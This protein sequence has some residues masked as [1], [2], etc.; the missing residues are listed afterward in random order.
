MQN[1]Q[2]ALAA[3]AGFLMLIAVIL[4]FTV[5][6]NH[7]S[8]LSGDAVSFSEGWVTVD[9][10]PTSLYLSDLPRGYQFTAQRTAHSA[11]CSGK[12][13]C[14]VSMNVNLAV[15]LDDVCI[16]RFAPNLGGLYGK[17]YGRML[18]TVSLPSYTGDR[19]L[20]IEMELLRGGNLTGMYNIVLQDSGAYVRDALR[21]DT[22]KFV[23]GLLNFGFGV[24]LLMI[25]IA[26]E[27]IRGKMVEPLCL[28]ATAM[29]LSIWTNNENAILL[30]VSDNPKMIRLLSYLALMLIPIPLIVF[31]ASL[32]K[33]ME[34]F[35]VRI[36]LL[37]S[38]LNIAM[39][40]ILVST[41]IC[42]YHDILIVSH[43]LILIG[44]CEIA[45]LLISAYIRKD[46]TRYQTMFIISAICVIAAGGIGDMFRFY[47]VHPE[48]NSAASRIAMLFFVGIL[49]VYEFR[50]Q[51]S[52][53][54]RSNEAELM[55]KLAMEDALTGLQNR[56]AFTKYEQCLLKR[57]KG[58]CLFLHFDVNHLKTVNDT[59]GHAAGDQH[60]IAA[61]DVIRRSFGKYGTCFRVGGDEFFAVLDKP[62]CRQDYQK[63]IR[64][65]AAMQ[66]QYNK[67]EL[68][69]VPL[70][71]AYGMAEYQCA[72]QN[73]E[74]AE[75]IADANMYERKKQMKAKAAK[76]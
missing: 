15:W 61:A 68:P 70:A 12:A 45:Y 30:L 28:G 33:R 27:R 8:A 22:G 50:E 65:F 20:R 56:T 10:T 36:C 47:F 58:T 7:T 34:H 49:S 60:I 42:D 21:R 23:I 14:F 11:E 52:I 51:L 59:Y 76:K 37:A 2:K 1:V 66:E 4:T 44:V 55:E 19:R 53:L 6:H 18:H 62:S 9:G 29:I 73:P 25:G 57:T 71:I 67:K 38:L 64:D 24:L 54:V 16:Y 48:D 69:A 5:S 13:L 74:F 26:Q 39:Q 41:G 32:T 3:A 72:T 17:Y 43:I 40:C 31:I 63:G 46:I 75:R 35:T